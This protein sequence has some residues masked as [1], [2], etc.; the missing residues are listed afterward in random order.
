MLHQKKESNEGQFHHHELIVLA[1]D[2]FEMLV[3]FAK[4]LHDFCGV[5]SNL[6]PNSSGFSLVST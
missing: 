5:C 4:Y 3:S 6:A 2:N 1:A